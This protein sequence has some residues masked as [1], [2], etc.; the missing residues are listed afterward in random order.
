[1]KGLILGA[2]LCTAPLYA[3]WITDVSVLIENGKLDREKAVSI[4]Q[5]YIDQ[6]EK[7]LKQIASKLNLKDEQ[8]FWATI[9]GGTY[10]LQFVSAQGSLRYHKKVLDFI[11]SLPKNERDEKKFIEELIRLRDLENELELLREQFNNSSGF[12]Q[13]LKLG[14]QIAAKELLVKGRR[15]LLKSSFLF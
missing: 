14:G 1:M 8:G 13:S 5:G 10:K 9:R 2:L 11:Q 4:V 7:T 3:D 6:D 15:T 12:T